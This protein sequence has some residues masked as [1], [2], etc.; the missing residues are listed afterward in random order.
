MPIDGAEIS[1][2]G[3]ESGCIDQHIE[4][5]LGPVSSLDLGRC[6]AGD[7][8]LLQIYQMNVLLIERIEV[9]ALEWHA[10]GTKSMI[11]RVKLSATS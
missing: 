4:L 9:T 11:L 10:A 5:M 3:I 1:C 8:H 2:N 6:D 7:G